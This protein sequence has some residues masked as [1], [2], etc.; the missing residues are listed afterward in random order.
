MRSN[1]AALT[2]HDRAVQEQE[3]AQA[4][5]DFWV[6]VGLLI[7]AVGV[8]VTVFVVALWQMGAMR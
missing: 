4:K 3:E 7:G 2:P 8:L 5:R 1:N 6:L